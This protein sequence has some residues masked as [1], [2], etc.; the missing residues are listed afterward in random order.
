[1][2]PKS[3][4]GIF[5][6]L[7]KKFGKILQHQSDRNRPR[8]FFNSSYLSI[9]KKNGHEMAGLIIVYIFL[10]T[11][12]EGVN[13]LSKSFGDERLAN[14]IHCFEM[15]LLLEHFCKMERHKEADLK[16][17][18][19]G[20][21]AILDFIKNTL[22]RTEGNGMKIIK[23]HLCLHYV[24]DIRRYGSMRNFDSCIGERHHCSEVKDPAKH[25]QR[26]RDKFEIQTATRYVD[27]IIISRAKQDLDIV[28][29]QAKNKVQCNKRNNIIYERTRDV[30]MKKDWKT[31]KY[32]LCNWPDKNFNEQLKDLC[33]W[34]VDS[35]K[36]DSP[37][38]FFTQHNRDEYIFRGDPNYDGKGP[39][40]DWVNVDWSNG[41]PI[42]AKINIFMDLTVGYKRPFHVGSSYINEPGSYAI[43]Y[44]CLTNAKEMSH[45]TSLLVEYNELIL[46]KSGRFKGL[47]Q[48]CVFNVES[49]ESTC[50]ACP[51]FVKENVMN[52]EK[53]SILRPRMKWNCILIDFLQFGYESDE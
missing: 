8:T 40:Y 7:C 30:F 9:A 2:F 32:I 28:I 51:Y 35:K 50:I 27:N 14:F 6:G 43:A 34:L 53:W 19:N 38:K 18:E 17:M 42:P 3:Y 41:E 25:T 13:V 26:R 45:P 22:N 10:F 37:I 46:N 1:V 20:I 36:T 33:R 5:E 15:L 47:P 49:I 44:S 4:C 52:A 21:P 16:T 24:D 23:F 11:S 31:K 29:K 12:D 39:W 48:L